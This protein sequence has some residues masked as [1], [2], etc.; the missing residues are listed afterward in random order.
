MSNLT[1][2]ELPAEDLG[3]IMKPGRGTGLAG[4]V[5]QAQPSSP[6]APA[7]QPAPAPAELPPPARPLAAV[8][9]LVEEPTPAVERPARK[10]GRPRTRSKYSTAVY[11]S[12]GVKARFEKYRHSTKSTNLDVVLE[13]IS[14]KHQ[15]GELAEII[16]KSRY[17]TAR[18]NALFPSD[19]SAVRYLGGGSSQIAFSP[20]AEQDRVIDQLGAELGFNTRSTWIAPVLNA[21]LPGRRDTATGA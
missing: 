17:S 3:D 8:A 14:A 10:P 2:Q 20:T 6:S 19:P 15:A 9:P 1:P 18:T 4:L 7:P 12:A 13:A 5:P 21:F 11:V 16:D